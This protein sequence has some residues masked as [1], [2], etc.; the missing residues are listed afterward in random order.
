MATKVRQEL[1]WTMLYL[2]C[3]T[4]LLSLSLDLQNERQD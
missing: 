3:L 4:F 1:D 2:K